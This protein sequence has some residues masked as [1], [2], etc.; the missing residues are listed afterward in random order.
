VS[1]ANWFELLSRWEK[2]NMSHQGEKARTS[3][4]IGNCAGLKTHKMTPR[5]ELFP[6]PTT[7]KEGQPGMLARETALDDH[8]PDFPINNTFFFALDMVVKG[9]LDCGHCLHTRR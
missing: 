1:L 4:L 7:Q 8:P 2:K 9:A 3:R 5:I 6:L